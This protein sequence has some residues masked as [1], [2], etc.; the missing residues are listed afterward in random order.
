MVLL[1]GLAGARGTAR[2]G[3]VIDDDHTETRVT[4][5]APGRRTGRWREPLPADPGLVAVLRLTVAVPVV[6]VLLWAFR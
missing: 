5:D 1:R 3:A 6:T 4:A 2:F